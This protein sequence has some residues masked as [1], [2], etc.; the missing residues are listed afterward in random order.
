ME[1][2]V[3]VQWNA[4]LSLGVLSE[5]LTR[6]WETPN[7]WVTELTGPPGQLGILPDAAEHWPYHWRITEK[8]MRVT[9]SG[10]GFTCDKW[11]VQSDSLQRPLLPD[12]CQFN[13]NQTGAE[14][15]SKRYQKPVTP[16]LITVNYVTCSG[17]KKINCS[18]NAAI[19]DFD[20]LMDE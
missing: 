13:L 7:L 15:A 19:F 5:A 6:Y 1:V 20:T 18:F 11:S 17:I 3:S 2:C 16:K 9:V 12:P 14:S 10:N 8:P 4:T